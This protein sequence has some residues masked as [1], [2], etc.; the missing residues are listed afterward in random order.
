M[1]RLP[2]ST[3]VAALFAAT[4]SA[5]QIV[6]PDFM[7]NA[8]GGTTQNVFRELSNRVQCVYDTANFTNQ[9]TAQPIVI[10]SVEFRLG[11]GLATTITTYP[12]VEIHLQNAAVDHLALTTTFASNRSAP[13]GTPNFSGPVT[14]QAVPGTTPNGYFVTIPLTTPFTYFPE[15]GSDLLME[16]VINGA[17][18]PA[19]INTTA[20]GFGTPASLCNSVRSPGSTVALTGTVSRFCPL[21]RFGYTNAPGAALKSNY[22]VG[23]YDRSVSLYEQFAAGASDLAGQRISMALNGQ[24]GYTATTTSGAGI[25]AP[26]NVGLALGD[27]QVSPAIALPFTFEFPGGSASSI[28]VDSNGSIILSG[29]SGSSIGGN[30]ATMLALPSTRICASIQDLL[31]DGSTNVANVFAQVDARNA[32][33]FYITWV[34]VPCFG[35]TAVPPPVCNMQIALI[36]NGTNDRFELRYLSYA[37]DSSSNA[38][39]AVTGFSRGSN[40]VDGGSQDFTAGSPSSQTE[41]Q[42]VRLAATNRPVIGLTQNFTTSN[43]PA[44]SALSLYVLSTGQLN[45]GVDL[46]V[47]G[48]AGCNAYVTLPEVLSILQLTNPTATSGVSIP[49]DP[50]FVGQSFY[51]QAV[52][53]DATANAAGL[54]VSNGVTSLMGSL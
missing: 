31:P 24:G 29:A 21:A 32:N 42:A 40:G 34:N 6:V 10:N 7:A 20:S 11:G 13:L 46:G 45:P 19:V 33:Q 44:T 27:D 54:L 36:N 43:I 47:I 38:G 23:C 22:G 49:N 41:A 52:V 53:L 28:I 51:S 2:I 48:A 1:Q 26:T 39:V 18:T 25:V 37:N 12:L 17:P 3:V 14:L 8:E 35:S 50:F 16:L 9:D 5:Q 15:S 30:A 4:L